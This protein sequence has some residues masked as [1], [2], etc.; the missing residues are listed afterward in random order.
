[1]GGVVFAIDHWMGNESTWNYEIA[2]TT[3]VYSIFRRNMILLGLWNVVHPL[4]MDSQT[5]S[6]IFA[7]GI[8]D[9]VFIDGDHR[10]EYVKKDI[11]SWLPKLKDGGIICGHDCEGHFSECSSEV[12]K[13]IESH[14]GDDYL[15]NVPCHPGVVRAL[16]DCFHDI[17]SIMPNSII[18]YYRKGKINKRRQDFPSTEFKF[19]NRP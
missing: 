19:G 13:L 5:A 14:L 2:R 9:L 6:R 18:W 10:Y 11:L 15:P 8:L 4:V 16:H 17:Y 7:D 12:K 3:D 1:M